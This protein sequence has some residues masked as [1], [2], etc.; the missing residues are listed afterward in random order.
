[1]IFKTGGRWDGSRVVHDMKLNE[2][3]RIK[4]VRYKVARSE[5]YR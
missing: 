4:L 2:D 5:K 3:N 1:M